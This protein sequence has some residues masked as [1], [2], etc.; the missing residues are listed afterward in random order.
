MESNSIKCSIKNTEH[1]GQI[2]TVVSG[3]FLGVRGLN[4]DGSVKI[5]ALDEEELAEQDREQRALL[6]Y[7]NPEYNWNL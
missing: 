4:A 7:E 6:P 3:G 2:L 5:G 1:F